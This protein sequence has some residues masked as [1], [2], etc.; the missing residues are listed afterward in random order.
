MAITLQTTTYNVIYILRR[1]ALPG[2]LKIGKTSVNAYDVA[3]LTPNCEAMNQAV[4]D[5]YK[6]DANTLALI[7]LELLHTEVAYYKGSDGKARMFDDHT[8]HDVLQASNYEKVEMTTFSGVADEWYKVDLEHAISAIEAVKH[9]QTRIDG[10]KMKS[11]EHPNI[12]FREE[13][14]AAINQTLDHYNLGG[15]KMLWNA[16]MRFGKTLCALELINQLDVQRVLI[17]THRPTVRSGWFDD[18]HNIHF[19]NAHQYGSKNGKITNNL[20]DKDYEGKDL[21]TLQ[22]DLAN[23]GIRYIYFASMQDLRGKET[24]GK[25]NK[26]WKDNNK[27]VYGTKWDLIVFDEAHEGTQTPLGQEVFADLCLKNKPLLLYLSGT[28]FNILSQF[29]KEEIYTWDYVMEQEAKENWSHKH[30]N[31]TNPYEG[32]AQLHIYTYNLG[33]IFY[34]NPDYSRSDDDYFNFSEFF[35]VWTGNEKED[36]EIMP[37]GVSKGEF[38]HEK[39]VWAF[40]DLLC[41]E[42]PVSYYPYSNQNFRNALSHTLWMVPG[43]KQAKRLAELIYKH[44]LHTKYGFEVVNVAGE[45]AGIEEAKDD[46]GKIAKKEKDALNK[47]KKAVAVYQKTI[48]L[49]C[50][51]LTTGVSVPEWTGVF[52]LSGGYSTKAASY[53]QT[54]FRGQT[55]YKNGAIKQNCYAFDFAPDRTLTVVDDY[56]KMQP[57]SINHV[58]KMEDGNLRTANALRFMPVVVMSGGREEEYDAKSFIAKVNKAYTDHVVSHGFK[59]KRLFRNFAEFTPKDHELLKQIGSLIG[60]GRVAIGSDG[61]IKVADAGFTGENSGKGK[62]KSKTKGTKGTT[63]KNKKKKNDEQQDL[64][65]KSQNVLDCIFVRMPLLLFGAVKTTEGLT[66][67]DLLSD[68]FIDEE[69]WEEFMPHHFTKTMFRQIAH[70]LRVDVLIASTSEIIR[71]AKEADSLPIKQR[72]LAIAKMV[73][74]FR[75]PDKETVLTPWRVVNMHMTETLGG[76]DFYNDESHRILLDKP[77]FVNRGEITRRVFGGV[78]DKVLEINSKSGVYPLW[79]AYTFWRMQHQEGMSQEAEWKLWQTVLEQNLYVV[80]KTRMAEKITRRVLVGYHENAHVNLVSFDNIIEN[81]K[82]EKKQK[83]L[84]QKI[85]T[86]AT[87][88]NNKEK[89]MLSFKAVV[90]NPPYN[91]MDGGAG[92]SATP[93]YNLFVDLA[94][95]LNPN[96]ISVIMPAKWYT[97]GK[98]LNTFRKDMLTDRHIS[99][100]VDFTNSRDCFDGVDVAGGVC[101]FLRE[102]DYNGDCEF[103]SVHQGRK[104]KTMRNLS[105]G[106]TFVRHMEAVSIIEKVGEKSNHFYSERVRTQKPFGLRTYVKPLENGDITLRYSKGEG[107]YASS[108]IS[109]GKDMISEWKIIISY[110]TAEHAGQ[111]DK[112]GRKKI[113]SSLDILP[114]NVICTETYLVVDSF[115]IK[116]EAVHLYA[117]LQTRFVRF[118]V[119]L[120]ASTQHLSKEK[121]AYVPL[122]DFTS[123]SDIDWNQSVEDIDQQLY[124]KYDLTEEEIA[125]IESMIKPM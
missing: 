16:K 67:E 78:G 123:A 14:I 49:S 19:K 93:L 7:D 91:K 44:D 83:Q 118:F 30:P 71:E 85:L 119:A 92:V 107:P 39:D 46:A 68:D 54:I 106:D 65:K 58:H 102:A 117:Y 34:N 94:K 72:T 22:D 3:E 64:V 43:V 88:G 53:M 40:L 80:C 61:S 8:V 20:G 42:H 89:D 110:L 26:V 125:F 69:S 86:P 63:L 109:T 87:Y 21:K 79:V 84:I 33:E 111:T 81:I 104:N 122:Q 82:N 120:L 97:D 6:G 77:R 95:H 4:R 121:F 116:E 17:L 36:G 108:L 55:P 96:Y 45:G 23:Q 13:Q 124:R 70:L 37:D 62:T 112:D 51:R 2:L 90:G 99:K 100:L 76:Y 98:G 27:L 52:M 48:T 11:T 105:E 103:V 101:Y 114:P 47:V 28:P 60:G 41:C 1:D 66:I 59:S 73:A 56:I 113:L 38:V 9:E 50:G 15:K 25:G 115:K 29:Q 10:P 31:E 75:F 24:D 12:V 18:Y 32:L 5:R 74:R 35:R 57:S